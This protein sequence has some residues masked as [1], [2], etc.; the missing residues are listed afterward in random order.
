MSVSQATL[1]DG[2]TIKY[3]VVK[4]PP[5]GSM[6][7]TFFSP[8][9]SYV[10]QFFHDQATGKDPQRLTRLKAILTKYNPTIPESQGGA[11]GVTTK[12]AEYFRKLFCWP[13]GIVVKPEIGIVAPA[14]PKNYFF[15]SGPF[16]GK[17]KKGKWF[18]SQKLREYLPEAECGC[19][20]N[21]FQICILIARAVRRL[22]QAGLAHSDLS[23]NNILVDPKTGQAIAL[24]IDSLVVPR[25]FP[26][27]VL[28]TPG[29]IAPEVIA[30][31]YLPA[32]DPSRKLPS[33]CT[34]QHALAVLIYEYMLFR[35]P[36]RGPKVNSP[37]SAE[38]DEILSMG[39]KALFIEHPTDH[40]NR[41]KGLKIVSP[42]LGL[43]LAD[44]IERSFIKGLHNPNVRPGATEWERG[45]I[46]SWDLLYPCSN[47]SCTHKWFILYNPNNV[48]CPF[49]NTKPSGTIPLLKLLTERRPGE[50]KSDNQLI[51]HHNQYLYSWHIYDNIFPGEEADRTNPVAYCVF[52]QGKWLLINQ[53]LTSLT[54]PGGNPVQPGQAVELIDGVQ[55]QLAKE[56]HGRKAEVQIIKC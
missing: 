30:T 56:P 23:C 38:E 5:A 55:I 9:G 16:R 21:Y 53:K 28:G 22:H 14:Y 49:C 54:S 15:D 2:K 7:K 52:H 39:E 4:D 47:R 3:V 31:Q 37:K 43:Y 41:P 44:L 18:S 10:V 50:W 20:L 12:T 40:S 8:D 27:D 26:P 1:Q 51:V 19:W 35:H 13:T 34:D 17:E 42:S 32:L 45:L 6:K 11:K 48:K 36:L 33:I 24:D 25:M 29:Y 46:K